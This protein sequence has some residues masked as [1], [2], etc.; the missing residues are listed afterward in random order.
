MYFLLRPEV[1]GQLGEETEMDTSVS[2]P[3]V[4]TLEYEF[5]DWLGDDLLETYPC[6]IVTEKLKK[7]LMASE[8]S[9]FEIAPVIVSKSDIFD[10]LYEGSEL[11]EF[12]WLKITGQPNDDFTLSPKAELIVSERCLNILKDFQ[13]DN[14]EI[15]NLQ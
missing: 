12:Y 6:F 15:E 8:L 2:P 11:P 13:L 4:D 10:D 9:G 7:F 3:R 14:C 1:A 5:E